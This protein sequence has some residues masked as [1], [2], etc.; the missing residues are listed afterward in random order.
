[1]RQFVVAEVQANDIDNRLDAKG[2]RHMT[3]LDFFKLQAK[4]LYRDWKTHTETEDGIYEYHPRFF[5]VDEFLVY[6]EEDLDERDFCLQ[7]AQHLVAQTAG[8]DKWND[9]IKANEKE[10]ELAK[11]VFNGCTHSNSLSASREDWLMYYYGE[12]INEFPIDSQIEVAK[13]YFAEVDP[14]RPQWFEMK[15]FIQRGASNNSNPS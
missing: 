3:H 1:M 9:L 6:Y 11:I 12:G 5:E 4:N 10:L 8:F 2:V 7:R 13:Y 15:N 14:P